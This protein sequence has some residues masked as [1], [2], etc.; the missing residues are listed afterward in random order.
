MS[1]NHIPATCSFSRQ[2]YF[3]EPGLDN[4]FDIDPDC[5]Q[6]IENDPNVTAVVPRL[7]SFALAAVA[8]RTQGVMVIG[9]DPEGEDKA[10]NIRNRLVRYR[11]TPEAVEA[12]KGESAATADENFLMSSSTSH[13]LTS[14]RLMYRSRR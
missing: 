5:R 10:L 14:Q 1:L 7:E 9:M 8:S 2:D 12:L 4:S 6:E 11:L 3:D 13:S